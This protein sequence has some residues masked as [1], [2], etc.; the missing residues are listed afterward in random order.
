MAAD[1]KYTVRQ[2]ILDALREIGV[3][4]RPGSLRD[5]EQHPFAASIGVQ[6]AELRDEVPGLIA[7]GYVE[8]KTPGRGYLLKLTAK[9]LDQIQR[10]ADPDE[11]VWGPAL[12]NMA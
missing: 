6:L 12:A 11:Y 5:I 1:E 10:E 2:V 9:G 3:R 4:G 7:H 8:N